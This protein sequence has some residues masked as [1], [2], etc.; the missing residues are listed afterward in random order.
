MNAGTLKRTGYGLIIR[1]K[2]GILKRMKIERPMSSISI[3]SGPSLSCLGV[4]SIVE[5][6]M[7]CPLRAG[8][9]SQALE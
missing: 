9:H 4:G 6:A 3:A 8:L 7:I 5:L 1:L 2:G